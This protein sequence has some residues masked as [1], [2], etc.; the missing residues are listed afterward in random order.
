M[1]WLFG[2]LLANQCRDGF[3]QREAMNVGGVGNAYATALS[4]TPVDQWV[5][6]Q[7]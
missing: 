1:N 7:R 3:W 5:I 2:A 4:L 6:Y